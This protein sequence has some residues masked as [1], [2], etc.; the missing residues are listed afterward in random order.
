MLNKS[1]NNKSFQFSTHT[2]IVR[3][4]IRLKILIKFFS[5]RTHSGARKLKCHA[6]E[7]IKFCVCI[8]QY[9]KILGHDN[10]KSKHKFL[11]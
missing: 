8:W 1:N 7:W 10:A 9:N 11:F 5:D 4:V 3:D 2:H 6:E